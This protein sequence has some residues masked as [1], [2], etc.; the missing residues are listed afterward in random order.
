MQKIMFALVLLIAKG[1]LACPAGAPAGFTQIESKKGTV[2]YSNQSKTAVLAVK[3]E[4]MAKAEAYKALQYF[5]GRKILNE[6]TSYHTIESS[7]DVVSRIYFQVKANELVQ[8]A[9]TGKVKSADEIDVLEKT[10]LDY[11]KQAP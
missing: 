7:P 3:C 6:T 2:S 9:I 1:L 8:A 11:F 5:A 4:P 10:I